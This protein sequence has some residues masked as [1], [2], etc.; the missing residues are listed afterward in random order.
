VRA[1]T[2]VSAQRVVWVGG[3]P[4]KLFVREQQ[5]YAPRADSF[6]AARRLVTFFNVS[7]WLQGVPLR[8][9]TLQISVI[10]IYCALIGLLWRQVPFSRIA[11]LIIAA[12]GLLVF[13]GAAYCR[14]NHRGAASSRQGYARPLRLPACS[15]YTVLTE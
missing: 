8:G 4:L 9:N 11:G 10:A 15:L 12:I 6:C 3:R 2:I 14:G 7:E 13:S 5:C 1:E